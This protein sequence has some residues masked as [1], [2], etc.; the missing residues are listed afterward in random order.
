MREKP[1]KTTHETRV[2]I[3]IPERL[4]IYLTQTLSSDIYSNISTNVEKA[5]V[6][7]TDNGVCDNVY[8]FRN[9][10]E[11]INYTNIKNDTY[12]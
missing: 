10:S 2:R 4:P 5:S 6:L 12:Y 7:I 3:I 8:L 1:R 9:T 11:F